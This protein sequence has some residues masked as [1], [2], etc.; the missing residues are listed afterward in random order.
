MIFTFL[1]QS[2]RLS[3]MKHLFSEKDT[4]VLRHRSYSRSL[5]YTSYC[6]LQLLAPGQFQ[7]DWRR[8]PAPGRTRSPH[9]PAAV[10]EPRPSRP[11]GYSARA[12]HEEHK[13]PR[14][15]GV[16]CRITR[17]C[18]RTRCFRIFERALPESNEF[19]RTGYR[20]WFESYTIQRY[21]IKHC[22]II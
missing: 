15:L 13:W 3:Y 22:A 16:V 2:V 11:G 10:S 18:Q 7:T 14:I 9:Q 4:E 12:D 21:G 17:T 19:N 5:N 8:N 1:S 20:P 6:R